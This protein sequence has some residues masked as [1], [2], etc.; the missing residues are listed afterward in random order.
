MYND[1]VRELFQRVDQISNNL[2]RILEKAELWQQ[3]VDECP[4]AIALFTANMNF[5]LVNTA[6]EILS[7][8]SK[9][10][11]LDKRLSLVIPEGLRKTHMDK[12]KEFA[13]NPIRKLNRHGL[14]PTIARKNKAVI[15]VKI[16]LSYIKHDNK[17]Y[18]LAFISTVV[19]TDLL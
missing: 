18:Y 17:I 14:T 2:D 4:L 13:A 8:Y 9:E 16:D 10:E 19:N 7:G 15:P 1:H 6:F 11:I 3:I 5:F 12:E